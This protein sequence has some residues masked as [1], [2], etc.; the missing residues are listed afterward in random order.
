EMP[1]WVRVQRMQRDIP[2]KF[3]DAGVKRSDL[4]N[5]VDIELVERGKKSMEIRGREVGLKEIKGGEFNLIRRDYRASGSSEAF[6]SFEDDHDNISG[7][8]RLRKPSSKAHRE[9]LKNSSM[10]REMKVL[11]NVVPVGEKSSEG[12][13]HKGLGKKLLEESER[14]SREEWGMSR[15]LVI[16]GIGVREYFRKTGYERVGPYMGKDI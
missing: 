8:I 11:G 16:S 9:E 7:F 1:P 14:I 10:I 2:V 5:L 13:Q 12:F 3:I 6:L 4:R 15:I